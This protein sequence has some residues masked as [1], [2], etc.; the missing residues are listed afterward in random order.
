VVADN[1]VDHEGWRPFGGRNNRIESIF[2]Q[3][4][5]DAI[6]T[7]QAAKFIFHFGATCVVPISHGLCH[8]EEFLLK[9]RHDLRGVLAVE[10]NQLIEIANLAVRT[11]A[12][13]M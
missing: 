8:L 13:S 7:R 12:Q 1:R 4:L 3:R 6:G 11:H 2:C 10:L 9:V 5:V